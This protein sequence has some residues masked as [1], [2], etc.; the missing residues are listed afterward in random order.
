MVLTYLVV[1]QLVGEVVAEFQ[2]VV[3]NRRVRQCRHVVRDIL[4]LDLFEVD[5]GVDEI[6]KL[7]NID[8]GPEVEAPE[9]R[10]LEHHIL[11]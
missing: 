4:N 1:I 11:D 10:N 5:R 6:A 8:F 9:R 3:H 2:V 7:L